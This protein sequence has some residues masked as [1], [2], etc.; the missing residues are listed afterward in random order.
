MDKI[1]RYI[2]EIKKLIGFKYEN[3]TQ[4]NFM[5]CGYLVKIYRNDDNSN[6]VTF[7]IHERDLDNEYAAVYAAQVALDHFE[8]VNNNG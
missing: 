8:K 1:E 2:Y 7:A 3:E 5:A 6:C 4:Y